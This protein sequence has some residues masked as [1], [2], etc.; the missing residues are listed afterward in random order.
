[1]D[2]FE[3]LQRLSMGPLDRRQLGAL[4]AAIVAS[5]IV[6]EESPARRLHRNKRGRGDATDGTTG[7]TS[8][9]RSKGRRRTCGGLTGRPCPRG[10][11]CI[12]D[13]SDSCDPTNGGADFRWLE[14]NRE[15]Y[16]GQ[17][18]A[19]DGDRLLA[20][21]STAKEVYSKA[22]AEGVEIPFVELVTGREPVSSTG[23]WLS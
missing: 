5:L 20:S 15:K 22:K 8:K 9:K 12:D 7:Q 11:I 6:A 13:P 1:M 17:W 4:S 3:R 2:L 21:G 23:G 18:V 16:L 10:Y 14:E 19:L